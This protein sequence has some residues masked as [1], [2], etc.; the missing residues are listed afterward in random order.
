M[1]S[2]KALFF[3]LAVII[4]GSLLLGAGCKKSNSKDAQVAK[5][6][7]VHA[8]SGVNYVDFYVNDE[9]L[10]AHIPYGGHSTY[11]EIVRE[12]DK[13]FHAQ[14]KDASTGLVLADIV[15]ADWYKWNLYSVFIAGSKDELVYG[16]FP[17]NFSL[18][19][20]GKVKLRYMNFYK[21]SVSLDVF[22]NTEVLAENKFYYGEN[23]DQSTTG[24]FDVPAGINH[25]VVREHIRLDTLGT[26]YIEMEEGGVYTMFTKGV[27]GT[28]DS[29]TVSLIRHN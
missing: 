13:G 3:S 8:L 24:Y 22:V 21:D 5:V 7:L 23:F 29:F 16:S 17:N 27:S 9:L 6:M 10:A 26:P 18:A 2:K 28:T 1:W 19:E 11:H 25:V 12:G 14:I 20:P 15:N 4:S